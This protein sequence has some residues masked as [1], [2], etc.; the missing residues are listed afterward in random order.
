MGI[1]I[2]TQTEKIMVEKEFS[3]RYRNLKHSKQKNVEYLFI[4]QYQVRPADRRSLAVPS[5][6]FNLVFK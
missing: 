2:Q 4:I 1:W 6:W 5:S 3:S